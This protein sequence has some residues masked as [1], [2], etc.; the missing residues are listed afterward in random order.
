M[1]TE[2][3]SIS[4]AGPGSDTTPDRWLH[5]EQKAIPA[6]VSYANLYDLIQM[7]NRAASG[8]SATTWQK[9]DCPVEITGPNTARV[10]LDL[11]VW[12]SSLDLAYSL[13]AGMGTISDPE[14]IDLEREFDL[15]VPL[16]DTVDIGFLFDGSLAWQTEAVNRSGEVVPQPD[17]R[18]ENGRLFL[19]A[20]VFGVL[21]LAGI[22][23]GY[24]HSVAMEWTIDEASRI[25]G[26]RNSV[27]A[28]WVDDDGRTQTETLDLEIPDCVAD[29]LATCPEDD[30]W[31]TLAS[32][33]TPDDRVPTIYYSTC[34]GRV[35]ALRYE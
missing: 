11:Y 28:A 3:L 27:I 24:R 9:Q 30:T 4:F 7:Y 16:T 22:A 34:T 35:L 5:L 12:P 8:L 32:V 17:A 18:I 25:T 13:S 6:V 1:P 31:A 23:S 10:T 14:R 21:R 26:I 15:V 33:T 19:S 20:P 29:M 2:S